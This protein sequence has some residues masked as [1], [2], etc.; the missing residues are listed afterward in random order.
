MK[1]YRWT[2]KLLA[3]HGN[4]DIIVMA[5]SV[6]QARYFARIQAEKHIREN[7]SFLEML[8]I[9]EDPDY[10][11]ELD[12]ELKVLDEDLSKEPEIITSGVILIRGSD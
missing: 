2:S 6:G 11:I 1:L 12:E 9:N 3:A 7:N 4:G 5:E 8:R 10:A